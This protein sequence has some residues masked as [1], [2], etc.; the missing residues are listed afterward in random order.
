MIETARR[1]TSPCAICGKPAEDLYTS[2]GILR[3]RGVHSE[4]VEAKLP[5]WEKKALRE[6]LGFDD[7]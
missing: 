7:D 4:C 5:E 6:L 1:G 3:Q 2:D